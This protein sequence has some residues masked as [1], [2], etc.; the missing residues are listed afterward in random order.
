M[1]TTS[2]PLPTQAE[3]VAANDLLRQV[4]RETP[5]GV[6]SSTGPEHRLTYFNDQFQVNARGRAQLG[7]PIGSCLPELMSQGFV[8]VLDGVYQGGAAFTQ[9]AMPIDV[10]DPVTHQLE[11][12]FYDFTFK[13]LRDALGQVKGLVAF[14][15]D[16]TAQVRSQRT[17]EGSLKQQQEFYETLLREVPA[18]IVAF[19]AEHR[20]VWANPILSLPGQPTDWMVGKTSAE[21]CAARGYGAEVTAERDRQFAYALRGRC[22]VSWEETVPAPGGPRQWLRHMRPVLG[23]DGEFQLMVASGLDVT[24]SR[25]AEARVREQ[26]ALMQHLLD[27]VPNPIRLTTAT[28]QLLFRNVAQVAV[29]QATM[30]RQRQFLRDASQVPELRLTGAALEQV[31]AT[32]HESALEVEFP[33]DNGEVRDYQVVMR[34]LPQPDGTVQVLTVA[35]DVTPLKVAQR[36]A[37][38]AA[39]AQEN[40]L[41]TVSH[42]IRTPLNGVLGMAGLL[43]NTDLSAEQQRY[44]DVVQHSGQHLLAILNDVLDMAKIRAG[45]LHLESVPVDLIQALRQPAETLSWQ[46]HEKGLSLEVAGFDEAPPAV[47]TDPVRL[48]QVL[49]NLLGNALKFTEAGQ[50]SLHGAVCAET[51][52]TLTV[53]FSVHDTGPGLSPAAQEHI[54][55]AFVQASADTT[56]R[57]GGT[58]LGLAISSLLVNQLGGH[59][60]VC[61]EPGVGSTFSFT[62]IFAKAPKS[63]ARVPAART[64]AT[65]VRGW[66]VLLVDDNALNLELATAVLRQNGVE[67]DAAVSGPAALLLFEQHTYHAVLM[68]VR[69]P[70]MSGVEATVYIRNHQDPGRAATP[71]LALTADAFRGQHEHYRAAGMNDVLTKPFTE[72]ELISKLV[73][74][75]RPPIAG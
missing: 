55:E 63:A 14:A 51:A 52:E 59:L 25:R 12:C 57:Y 68:D 61:S 17:A 43:A 9:H 53:R 70:G 48:N 30:G 71:V 33:M 7:Q 38:A 32:G 50:V 49:L 62:I 3:L 67:V 15:V 73:G 26:R 21:A 23:P 16:V 5:A 75:G 8:Q 19:D 35:T 1:E 4:L 13:P 24:E 40:F 72:S 45:Q 44:L 28:G 47:C 74:A 60:S 54:F 29:A 46:A 11:A 20:Y 18:G 65:T 6:A 31:L 42:E 36:S 69:M 2:T 27:A 58:G 10:F 39:Q 41:A 66:R 37:T 22:Q 64:D 34:P 56:R